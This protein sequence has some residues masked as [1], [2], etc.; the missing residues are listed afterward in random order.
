MS[1]SSEPRP[2]KWCKRC[3]ADTECYAFG[4]CIAC[5]RADSAKW[6]EKNREHI[7]QY[8]KIRRSQPDVNARDREAS[9][10]WRE[11]NPDRVRE[12][13]QSWLSMNA[14]QKRAYNREW[15]RANP[16]LARENCQRRRARISQALVHDVPDVMVWEFNPAGPGRCNYCHE[17]LDFDERASW[18]VDHVVPLSRGGAHEIGNLVVACAPCNRSKSAKLLSEWKRGAA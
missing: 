12:N 18:H 5:S 7:R 8:D 10:R 1:K 6:R 16:D 3:E 2:V 13:Y 11:A 4:K 9:R 14:E 15:N 17:R